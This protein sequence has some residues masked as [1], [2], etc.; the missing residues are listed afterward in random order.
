MEP[1]LWPAVNH[2]GEVLEFSDKA[3]ALKII[4]KAPKR[5]GSPKAVTTDG[6]RSYGKANR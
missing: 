6:L 3:A 1:Y 4:R 2:E 5:H